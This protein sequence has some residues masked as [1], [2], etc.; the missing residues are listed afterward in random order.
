M[1]I[2]TA[3]LPFD[4]A[5]KGAS[6]R[7]QSVIN[8]EHSEYVEGTSGTYSNPS[9]SSGSE[10][11]WNYY[12]TAPYTSRT[13]NQTIASGNEGKA[14][15][16]V[17]NSDLGLACGHMDAGAELTFTYT[18]NRAVSGISTSGGDVGGLVGEME[19]GAVFTL[20]NE[21]TVTSGIDIITTAGG[22][23]AGGLVGK[24]VGGTVNVNDS[25]S[26]AAV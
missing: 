19:T 15:A 13:I 11:V 16:I 7:N 17:G 2:K 10:T 1:Q 6:V 3:T 14:V 25:S 26:A 24:N 5:T 21:N 9:G 20:K 23:Y 12:Y 4:I 18:A 22:S 8:S